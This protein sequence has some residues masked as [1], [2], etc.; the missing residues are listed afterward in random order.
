[1]LVDLGFAL[2]ERFR[3]GSVILPANPEML[4]GDLVLG[5]SPFF[6]SRA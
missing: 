4:P 1:M 5:P 2:V 6:A 3:L